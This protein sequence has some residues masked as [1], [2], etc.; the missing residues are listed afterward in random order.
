MYTGRP[1]APCSAG[2]APGRV[3]EEAV[4]RD[5]NSRYPAAARRELFRA[6]ALGPLGD[7]HARHLRDRRQGAPQPSGD[8]LVWLNI[9]IERTPLDTEPTPASAAVCAL[10]AA[11]ADVLDHCGA[12]L[13][14]P[15]GDPRRLKAGVARLDAAWAE[16]E[17]TV[18]SALPLRRMGRSPAAH[19]HSSRPG[20]RRRVAARLA[21][22]RLAGPQAPGQRQRARKQQALNQQPFKC[23]PMRRAACELP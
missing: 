9:I 1:G 7:R 20:A 21:A 4:P 17:R 2:T 19:G 12:L 13:E 11:A 22:T 8:E 10:K 15:T 16:M 6:A 23:T 5:E 3:P 18:T 14:A